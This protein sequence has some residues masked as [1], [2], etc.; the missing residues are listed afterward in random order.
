MEG[1]ETRSALRRLLGLAREP[2]AL[3]WL[4]KVP[5]DIP[6]LEKKARFCTKLEMATHDRC[7]YA[8]LEEEACTGGAR[9]CGLRDGREMPRGR[10]SGEFLVAL[11]L[12]RDVPA[13]Q[14]AWKDSLSVEPGIFRALA[15]APLSTAPFDP[16][17]VFVLCDADQ[18]MRLL[19]ANGYDAGAHAIGGD[20]GPICSTMGAT[21]YLTGQVA[22]GFG[23]VGARQNMNLA[24][25]EVMVS[26]PGSALE[27]IVS[28]L[29]TM[30]G[31]KL[32]KR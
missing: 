4:T 6:R 23:D 7:F 15:F 2:V 14:R 22:Y 32:Y 21:P 12:Y 27:R 30:I 24:P 28:N 19:H 5:K 13:V 3:K 16:D 29:E 18:G 10:R 8:T 25:G 31:G 20:A 26:L 17:V 11:G 9:Y 1:T